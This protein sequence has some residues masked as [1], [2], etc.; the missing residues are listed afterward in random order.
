MAGVGCA[1]KSMTWSP[2]AAELQFAMDRSGNFW[3]KYLRCACQIHVCEGLPVMRHVVP[4]LLYWW[5]FPWPRFI[6]L[7]VPAMIAVYLAQRLAVR[8]QAQY[9][10][11][12]E[13]L[14][15]PGSSQS[16]LRGALNLWFW[17]W[18][19]GPARLNDSSLMQSVRLWRW[20]SGWTAFASSYAIII[21][22]YLGA[23]KDF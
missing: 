15:K 17:G 21:G 2:T 9:P 7:G 10:T 14:G 19:R 18:T 3:K 16:N 20:V 4:Y 23:P 5:Y 8:I 11:I 1:H 6:G 13:G 22:T 12:W